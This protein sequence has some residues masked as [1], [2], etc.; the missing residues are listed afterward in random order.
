MSVLFKN[1]RGVSNHTTLFQTW[2]GQ[3]LQSNFFRL[4]VGRKGEGRLG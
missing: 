1:T 2:F 3:R 4:D